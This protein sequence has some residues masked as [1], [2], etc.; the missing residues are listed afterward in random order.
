MNI[1]SFTI[2]HDDRL[3]HSNFIVKILSDI[4]GIQARSGCSCAGPYGHKLLNIDEKIS[5]KLLKWIRGDESND[6][7]N[8]NGVKFGWARINLHY[9]LEWDDLEYMCKVIEFIAK[10]GYKFL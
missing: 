3:L 10:H 1:V 6:D 8:F 2:K 5:L 4:F 9:S 7:L